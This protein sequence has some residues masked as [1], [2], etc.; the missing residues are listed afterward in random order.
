VSFH[1]VIQV[2][3]KVPAIFFARRT[4]VPGTTLTGCKP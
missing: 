4:V 1:I 2:T 3:A